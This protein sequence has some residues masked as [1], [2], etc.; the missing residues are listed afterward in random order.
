MCQYC[1]S[2][3]QVTLSG[4]VPS[5]GSPQKG[6]KARAATPANQE[7]QVPEGVVVTECE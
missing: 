5:T 2:F 3:L 7:P 6:I 4:A 1:L